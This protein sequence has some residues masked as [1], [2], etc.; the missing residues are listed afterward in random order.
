MNAFRFHFTLLIAFLFQSICTSAQPSIPSEHPKLIVQV[1]VS[2]M[3]YDYLQRYSDK[4]SEG[5]F[6]HIMNEGTFC[7]NAR[8]NYLLTQSLPGLAT[9]ATGTN[10]NV[11][12]IVSNRW[13]DP[14][15]SAEV[16]AIADQRVRTVGGNYFNGMYSPKNLITSTIGDEI[17]MIN[18]RSKVIGIS[19]EPSSAIISSGH[20]ANA[21][22]WLD[23]ERGI[24]ISNTHYVD[25]L[26]A[27]VDSLNVKGYGEL[28]LK[29]DWNLLNPLESYFESDTATVKD[30]N[31]LK[32]ITAKLSRMV[33]G[34]V[35]QFRKPI[36]DYS[37]L[38]E[39]PYGNSFTKDMAIAAIIG[40]DLG[41]DKHTDYLSITFTT[42]RTI[43]Q[44]FGPHAIETED[45]FL[46][47]DRE[48]EHFIAFLNSEIGRHNY[49]LVVTSDQGVGAT[50]EHLEKSK[51]PG[52]YFEPEKAIMLLSSYLNVVYGT[53]S[54]VLGYQEK[55]IYLNR[56]LIEDSNLSLRD[57]Q[58][59]VGSF[60]LQFTGVAN[61]VTA[62][63][64]QSS[65]FTNGIFEK[66]QNS[67]NQRRS[68]D[69]IINLEPG[70]VERSKNITSANSPY[71][72]DTHVPLM[73]YGWK[74]KRKQV[75]T[76]VDMSDVAPTI[77]TLM[78]I[79]WPSGATGKPI[80]EII[81]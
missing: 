79:G 22:Y 60:M 80:R 9:I 74:M 63:N 11:H 19:L 52:G 62:Y 72:Y 48:L 30:P 77:S 20:N 51:I 26:P 16:D 17:R 58:D 6:K 42:T 27:W 75:L 68:G 29:R 10:P 13:F 4:F 5:G 49:L 38:F 50:P 2:Q 32:R 7:R 41:K 67:F 18:P 35:Q 43:G 28:Y 14:L 81:E 23:R 55:Q 66:F 65:N 47:L 34:M 54:W 33:S 31:A 78:G 8:Y 64:L 44:K 39:T 21:A 46:R 40:E 56:R 57:F 59:R 12:G 37:P 3:R 1:V 69:V 73:W 15:T 71:N 36:K 25:N 70:W 61:A 24:W 76:P 53:A 45:A